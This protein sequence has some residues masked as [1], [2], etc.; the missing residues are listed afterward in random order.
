MKSRKG[1][2]PYFPGQKEMPSAPS[3]SDPTVAGPQRY[4]NQSP[5]N[6]D[7]PAPI[8][9]PQPPARE[10]ST[11]PGSAPPV[12]PDTTQSVPPTAATAPQSAACTAAPVREPVR[13]DPPQSCAGAASAGA[14]GLAPTQPEAKSRTPEPPTTDNPNSAGPVAALKNFPRS[15]VFIC[16]N[17]PALTSPQPTHVLAR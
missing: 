10:T 17:L 8:D 2:C 1:S 5:S 16:L 3:H 7:A 12:N 6:Q 9:P 4:P 11:P 15:K 14:P 13:P